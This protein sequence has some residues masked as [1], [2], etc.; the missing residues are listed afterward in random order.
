MSLMKEFLSTPRITLTSFG[1]IIVLVVML[2]TGI[3]DMITTCW[4]FLENLTEGQEPGV[5]LMMIIISFARD[6]FKHNFIA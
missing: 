2:T 6:R 3:E 5:M 1:S 4:V